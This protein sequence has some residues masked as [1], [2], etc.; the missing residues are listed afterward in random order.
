MKILCCGSR[1]WTDDQT[2]VNAIINHATMF[3]DTIIIEGEARGADTLAK[4]SA[5]RMGIQVKGYPADWNT[6]GKSAGVIRNQKMLDDNP[7]IGLVLAFTDNIETS[8]GTKDMVTRALKKGIKV[9][10]YKHVVVEEVYY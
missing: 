9:V 1:F 3:E 6:H 5:E 4:V 10:L 7:D 8:K 2:I